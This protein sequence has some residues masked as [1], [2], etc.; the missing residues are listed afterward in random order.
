MCVCSVFAVCPGEGEV[1]S[2]AVECRVERADVQF[3]GKFNAVDFGAWQVDAAEGDE[4]AL[5]VAADIGLALDEVAI[6]GVVGAQVVFEDAVVAPPADFDAAAFFR[7]EA[8]VGDV[9]VALRGVFKAEVGFVEGRR[10]EAFGV[11][12][13]KGMAVADIVER[14]ESLGELAFA[15]IAHLVAAA[16]GIPEGLVGFGV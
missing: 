1:A 7:F 16:D 14:A 11:V 9:A 5:R 6:A 10:A 12:G 15:V 8:G 13:V 2:Q 4:T 3:A